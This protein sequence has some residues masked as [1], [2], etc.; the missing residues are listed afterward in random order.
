MLRGLGSLELRQATLVPQ[1]HGE[2]DDG[3]AA[4]VHDRG[5]GGAVHAS[6]HGHCNR[7]NGAGSNREWRNGSGTRGQLV[8]RSARCGAKSIE[9]YQ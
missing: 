3:L 8:A 5:D 2:A 9:L 6:T 4:F 1:L 7:R